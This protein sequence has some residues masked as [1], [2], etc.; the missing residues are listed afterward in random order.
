MAVSVLI[1]PGGLLPVWAK[2]SSPLR[3]AG[4]ALVVGVASYLA[5]RLGHSIVLSSQGV[6]VLWPAWALLVSVLL[7]VP[8]AIWPVLIPAGIIGFV[9]DDFRV[10]FALGTIALLNLADTIQILIVCLG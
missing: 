5:A 4:L 6:S 10:G 3:T 8:R 2:R 7:L 1:A 9:V